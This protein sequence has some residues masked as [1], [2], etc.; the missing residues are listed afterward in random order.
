MRLTRTS[1]GCSS[2]GER[3]ARLGVRLRRQRRRSRRSA[4]RRR[5]S[6]GADTTG[7]G[8]RTWRRS[9]TSGTRAPRH[10]GHVNKQDGGD[11]AVTKLLT[12][13]KAGNG[14]P[15]V[16]QAEYQKIPTLVS[17]DALADLS[18]VV[19]DDVSSAILR[20][21]LGGRHARHATPSTPSRRTPARC[22]STTARTSSTNSGS[23]SR[24]P[25]SSTPRP[26][27]RS[28][29]RTRSATSAPSPPPTPAGSPAWRSRPARRGGASTAS[30]VGRHRR[31]G[32]AEGRR[33]W[34]GLVQEGVI[35]NKPM[36]TPEWNAALNNGNQVGWLSAIWGPGVLEGNAA[37]TAGKWK[38]APM[39]QWDAG[40]P[41]TGNWGGSSTGGDT[42]SE[43]P[44]QAAEFVTWLNTDPQAVK[45]LVKE[46]TSTRPRR[47]AS[48]ALT[49]RRRRSSPTSRTSTR[50]QPRA[51]R[52]SAPSPTARTSTSPTTPTTTRSARP[53]SHAAGPV[54]GGSAD[55]A[56]DHRGGHEE[57]RLHGRQ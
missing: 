53:R 30:L 8:R 17:A 31:R 33:Y 44:E 41:A 37:N 42:Q 13:I 22:S 9:W 52:R 49:A 38:M 5:R 15:D 25:G 18:D 28:T 32:H 35:D 1:S 57:V 46:S 10:P 2:D 47:R 39:P 12:A 50:S 40:D 19:G 4:V 56:V 23:R 14:A 7:P 36:Y 55:D 29:R 11:P 6:G 20:G 26:P 21:H 16:M 51:P 24:R 43:H 3:A 48:E 34:G 45:A 54:P 27:A